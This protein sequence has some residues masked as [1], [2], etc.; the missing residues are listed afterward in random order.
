MALRLRRV[1]RALPGVRRPGPSSRVVLSGLGVR[2]SDLQNESRP[3]PDAP[4]PPPARHRHLVSGAAGFIM[5]GLAVWG[6]G[7]VGGAPK[8]PAL[9]AAAAASAIIAA[10]DVPATA[11]KSHAY[12]A[13]PRQPALDAAPIPG[14]RYVHRAGAILRVEAKASGDSLKKEAKGTKVTLEALDDG[15][16]AK[17]TDG[18]IH[19]WMRAST[20]GVNPP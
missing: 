1:L 7:H 18:N 13:R 5:G 6:F 14:P 12:I 4:E 9:P 19:G 3:F 2:P 15:G 17:V 16:W 10:G 11:I 8:A 20:L